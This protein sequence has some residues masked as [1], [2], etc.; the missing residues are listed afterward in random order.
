MRL[1]WKKTLLIGFGFLASSLAWSLYNSLVPVMLENRFGLSTMLI[2]TIMAIDNFFGVVFQPLVGIL[3]DHTKTR[4]GRRMPWILIGLPLSAAA[5]FFIPRAQSLGIMM[6][7]IILFNF[8]MSVW[9]SPVIALMP[10]VT[11]RPLRSKANG[12]INL[13]GGIGS[14][15]AFF[16][17][18]RLAVA[19]KSNG[20]SFL[21]GSAVMIVSLVVL[22]LFVREPVAA[23]V[24]LPRRQKQQRSTLA[25][26]RS[27][28]L[29]LGPGELKSLVLLLA[30]IFFWF[31][32]YNAIETFF[33]LYITNIH[34]LLAGD[35]TQ[36][37][38]LF[39]LTF[40][41]FAF[42]AG[43]IGSRIGRKR[44][45]LI[46]LI[47]LIACFIPF[48]FLENL[49]LLRILLALGGIFWACININ[50]LPMVVELASDSKVGSFTGY[51]YF[52]S[53]SAAI[54][55]PIL[56]GFI[57]DLTK[58]YSI[59]MVYAC[60]AFALALLAVAF[61]RHGEAAPPDPSGH[62]HATLPAAAQEVREEKQ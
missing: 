55:S 59:L 34:G 26:I 5:F 40:V 44:T 60:G 25:S 15:I 22:V 16:V 10:D 49:L 14:I 36:M 27:T 24:S 51:Y 21:M 8:L 28:L 20:L 18:G 29:S 42:P 48:I 43:I 61:V 7:V 2:G 4:F 52:A 54:L 39:S 33:T 46:G 35:A 32:G 23:H 31:A 58:N 1:D 13:M 37:L 57:R 9:R 38:T 30:A 50:S 17:G 56:F 11:P 12:I 47:G 41:G 45:I 62:H 53:F 3:S 6:A 19:D